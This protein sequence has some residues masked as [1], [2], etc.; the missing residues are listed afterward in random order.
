MQRK[1]VV[2]GGGIAGLSTAWALARAGESD[3]TVVERETTLGSQATSQNAAILRTPMP[4]AVLE[5]FARESA[6]FLHDPPSGF[7]DVPLLD[8]CGLLIASDAAGASWKDRLRA[9]DDARLLD[10]REAARIAPH[11]VPSERDAWFVASEGRI[12]V[13]ALVAGFARGAREAG[14]R[15]VLGQR[16][17][18]LVERAR[19]VVLWDGSVLRADLVV[20]AAGAW[21]AE[22]ARGIGSR[23]ELSPMRRHL[24]VT[25]SD[26]RIDPR[27]PVVWT[28]DDPF[29]ARPEA[30]GLLLSPCDETVSTP[31]ELAADVDLLAT[32]FAKSARRLRGLDGLE[33]ARFWAG[34]R[35]HASDER[36][37]IGIDPDVERLMWVAGLGGH[38]ITCAASVGELA[39]EIVTRGSSLHPLADLF[40]PARFSGVRA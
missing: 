18:K 19:G 2:V 24:L 15:F 27:W 1:I 3:V 14:V 20:V 11:V 4:D 29:Y 22:L 40:S 38:G 21:A 36:F 35:T 17:Q 25:R 26:A 5:T 23:V 31:H 32:T 10:A 33:P 16:V 34:L 9:R 30:G 6:R 8:P 39:A 7:C 37:V 28:D 13:P 12:D